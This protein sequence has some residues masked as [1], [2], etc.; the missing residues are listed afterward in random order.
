MAGLP[1]DSTPTTIETVFDLLDKKL[2]S[3]GVPG[4]LSAVGIANVHARQWNDAIWCFA[5]ALAVWLA[6]K[7][8]KKLAP[9]IDQGLDHGIAVVKRLPHA[10][11]T[12]F[13]GLYLQQQ[14]RL[15]EEFTI[16]GFNPDRT[17]I[18]LL[19]D[20]FVPLD[21]SGA[22]SSGALTD[23]ALITAKN[24]RD[25]WQTDPSL[26]SENLDIWK[27]LA[28]TRKDRKFRQMSIL[29]KGGMGKTTLLRHITLIYGQGKHR[30][31]RAPTLVPVLLRLRDWV[32]ELNQPQ[33]LSLPQFITEYHIPSLSKNH[34]LTPPT[35]WAKGIL[36]KGNALVMFDGFDEIPAEN[37][38]QISRW[39]SEQ[40]A[41]YAQSVFILTS[42]PAGYR[43][44]TAKKPAIP[45][46]V[47][48]FNP[49]QQEAFIRRWYLCQERCCR[50]EKQHR[51]AKEVAQE[52]SGNLIAQLEARRD[53]LGYMA[54]NPLLLNMLVTF[55]RY[56]IAT[57]LPRQRLGLYQGI[58]KLQLDDRPRARFI[59]MLLP[60]DKS[61]ALLQSIALGMV[62][63][64]TKRL[65]IP[66]AML[67][68]YLG[69]HPLL[70]A[71]EVDPADWLKQIVD[72]SE[73][74]VEREPGEYE[75]PHAS[76]Q[77][78]FAATWLA[79]PQD[80]ETLQKNAQLVL[81]NWNDALWRETVLL[82][83]AQLTPGLL[84]QV[85]RKACEPGG[86]AAELATLALQEYPRPE[87]IG[88]DLKALLESLKDVAQDSKYRTL[89]KLLKAGKWRD[90]DEETYRLM[91]TTVGKEE[92]Q[93]FERKDL[94][95][96]PCEDLRTLDQLWVKYSN[97]KF[98]FS[99]QK[100]IWQECGSP[101][102]NSK[103]WDDFCVR[104]GWKDQTY[105]SMYREFIFDLINSPLGEL[106]NLWD[107]DEDLIYFAQGDLPFNFSS[108]AQ[109]L[110]KCS[111]SQF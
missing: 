10:L 70:Q 111:T 72:V 98:G 108:L 41:E 86:E 102:T 13:T 29:A 44:Y 110:V 58:C 109:R 37:R 30:R 66:H 26:R 9:E 69:Q 50:S 71:E 79:K 25:D 3:L 24:R 2:V 54:E 96:F 61:M 6:I 42:R 107:V 103:E 18:P 60:F 12:D 21:L 48:K 82:Y 67:I 47:N 88:N 74:L 46:Y 91:I 85:I 34:P 4:A 51:Q 57:D 16:E 53:E 99:V 7:I 94:E 68:G 1:P 80:Q 36:T 22:I 101:M 75:F 5:G 49:A 65:T 90:A 62:T 28:R 95:E 19:E 64:K 8:G 89:E 38:P 87:K 32:D 81:Q 56:D 14:T 23:S 20:V 78:F 45:I 84:N 76:F 39:L 93:W 83:T 59:Q 11:R 73:L 27:L 63:S 105:R 92:E 97:G 104:V 55:H 106:P 31:H 40:T 15:C 35:D 52:R 33:P 43:D 17:A 77:G 100:Q